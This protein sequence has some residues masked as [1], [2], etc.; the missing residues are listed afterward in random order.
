[1]EFE[2]EV[3]RT[4]GP[5]A[6]DSDPHETQEWLDAL[7]A[8]AEAGGPKRALY[9]I[10]RLEAHGQQLGLL[11]RAPLY[12]AYRNTIPLERQSPYP[13]E[14]ALEQRITSILRWNALAMVMRANAAYGDLGGHIASYASVAEIFELGLNHFFRGAAAPGGGDL[15]F[16]QPGWAAAGLDTSCFRLNARLPAGIE[17]PRRFWLR[18]PRNGRRKSARLNFKSGK[19][20]RFRSAPRARCF[21]RDNFDPARRRS[22]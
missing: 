11:R 20:A 5:S 7:Q 9:L 21:W 10:K 22:H 1:M 15:V 4:G 18:V 6:P 3:D 13:G 14:L 16:F 19:F 12:S 2:G 8:A 17:E